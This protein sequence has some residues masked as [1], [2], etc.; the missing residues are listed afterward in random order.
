MAAPAQALLGR[1]DFHSFETEWPNRMSSVRTILD[2]A[3]E[4]QDE[5]RHDRGRGRRISV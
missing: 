4:R 2:L 1:H 3:V 5:T